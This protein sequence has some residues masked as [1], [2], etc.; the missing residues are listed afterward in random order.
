VG[1]VVAILAG[2]VIAFVF[3]LLAALHLRKVFETMAQKTGESSFTTAGTLLLVGA[4]LTIIGIGL[5][6][7][8][9]AWI[10]A[11][12]GFFSMKPKDY[13]PQTNGYGY[14]QSSTPPQTGTQNTNLNLRSEHP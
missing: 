14:T 3:Y 5:I 6:L 8:L 9:I 2:L 7:I 4:V 10:F 12:V 13:Q 1:G 11:T